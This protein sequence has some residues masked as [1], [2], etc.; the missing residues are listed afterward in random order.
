MPPTASLK[1]FLIFTALFVN[2][3]ICDNGTDCHTAKS[4]EECVKST[5]CYWCTNLNEC[6]DYKLNHVT[7]YFEHC[8]WGEARWQY[9]WLN[10]MAMV[11]SC[12]VL[13]GILLIGMTVC[14]C[15]CN[16]KCRQRRQQRMAREEEE[17]ER[18]EEQ[19][20]I[21]SDERKAER[22]SRTDEV[23]TKYGLLKEDGE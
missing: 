21:K 13:A 1:I 20:R 12:S 6:Y 10:V 18:N 11:I 3:A 19:R 15:W 8:S 2:V 7:T 22:K 4:C 16:R 9:C 23:R 5:S 14:C 17:V